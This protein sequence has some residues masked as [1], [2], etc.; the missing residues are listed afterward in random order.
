[1]KLSAAEKKLARATDEQLAQ[2]EPKYPQAVLRTRIN[3]I[4]LSDLPPEQ[5]KEQARQLV[6]RMK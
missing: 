6:L 4:L 1:M 5:K 2:L 3:K